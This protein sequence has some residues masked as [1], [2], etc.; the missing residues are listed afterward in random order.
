MHLLAFDHREAFLDLF[1]GV[2]DRVA[3]AKDLAY[4]AVRAT[5][6]DGHGILVD[7]RLA[8]EVARRG[9]AD[10]D[11]LLAMPVERSGQTVFTFDYDDWRGHIEDFDPDV[12]KVLVR[13]HPDGDPSD[14]ALQRTRLKELA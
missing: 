11:V 13:Y 1:D 12:C 9:K 6:G 14:N 2:R 10:G 4:D 7:E 8:P 3:V 5:P